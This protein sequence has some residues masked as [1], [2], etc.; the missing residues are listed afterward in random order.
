MKKF[1]L[2]LI[3]PL[4]LCAFT[5]KSKTSNLTT[6]NTQLEDYEFFVNP[7]AFPGA[8]GFGKLATG[9]TIPM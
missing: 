5:V 7:P 1:L 9:G 3:A 8:E 2:L 4:L 6:L